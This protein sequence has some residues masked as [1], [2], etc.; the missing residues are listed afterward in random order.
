[1]ITIYMIRQKYC[2]SHDT[3]TRNI[4]IAHIAVT[5]KFE[6]ALHCYVKA[7]SVIGLLCKFIIFHD[8]PVTVLALAFGL[9]IPLSYTRRSSDPHI[10]PWYGGRHIISP[11]LTSDTWCEYRWRLKCPQNLYFKHTN[12]LPWGL[13]G[14]GFRG[15]WHVI[16]TTTLYTSKFTYI[17]P[18][19]L[20]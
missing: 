13:G 7:V 3:S 10:S 11:W 4:D 18:L 5:L 8:H 16:N 19:D 1:M 17:R 12:W 6:T 15:I 9:A 14:D 20:M 2:A